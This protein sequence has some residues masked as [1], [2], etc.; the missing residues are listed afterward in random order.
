[1]PAATKSA[2]AA[3]ASAE[4]ALPQVTT[5]V[6]YV[7]N[8]HLPEAVAWFNGLIGAS[9]AERPGYRVLRLLDIEYLHERSVSDANIAAE[10]DASC[11]AEIM[12][13]DP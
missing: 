7:K 9:V 3:S 8:L 10:Y 5:H 6:F 4:H 11:L 1:M 13:D 2:P 12:R